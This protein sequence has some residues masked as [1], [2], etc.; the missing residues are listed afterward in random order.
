MTNR[1]SHGQGTE[2]RARTREGD[3]MTNAV[4]VYEKGGQLWTTS[5]E[6]AGKF[7][8]RHDTVLRSIRNLE[9]SDDFRRRNFAE[10]S[11]LNEQ[12]KEHPEF[13]L[14]RGGFSMV[15]MGFT[16]RE[17]V[18]WKEMFIAAFDAME[19]RILQLSRQA[20]RRAAVD[21][22][23]ARQG[24]KEMRRAVVEAIAEFVAYAKGQGS[25]NADR[26]YL[27]ITRMTCRELFDCAGL[28]GGQ[29]SQGVRDFLNASQLAVLAA[30]EDTLGRELRDGMSR[31]LSYPDVYR[32]ARERVRA[33]AGVFGKTP[34]MGVG[35]GAGLLV[36]SGRRA[37]SGAGDR[38]VLWESRERVA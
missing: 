27:N 18:A 26:Y 9:C 1:G 32:Q 30:V 24:G 15:A 22:Q 6:V 7:G 29:L 37:R 33:F 8:K 11:Y 35:V 3:A 10:S 16:G 31:G 34:V 38:P 25:L 36:A 23:Q 17:A 20:E 2:Q 4:E 12:G 13:L 14:S 21:W 28:D 5:R 19:K